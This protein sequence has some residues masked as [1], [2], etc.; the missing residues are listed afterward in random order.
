[1]KTKFLLPLA[2]IILA[3]C[4]A[5]MK[6][7]N[8]DS[9]PQGARVFMTTGKNEDS[10]KGGRNYLGTTPFQWTTETEGD[11]TFKIQSDNIPFYSS[12]VQSVV[13]FTA[14]PPNDATNL[15]TKREVYHGRAQFQHADQVPQGIFFDLTKP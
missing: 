11:G 7:I 2:A 12:F 13:V 15:Y 10:A 14:E 9:Q 8:F 1:M 5:P 3:G 4:A 6:T